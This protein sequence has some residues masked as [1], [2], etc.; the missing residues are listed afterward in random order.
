ML[1]SLSGAQTQGCF[2]LCCH[3]PQ[4]RIQHPHRLHSLSSEASAKIFRCE[5]APVPQVL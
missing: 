1:D 4:E 3:L 5:R 2:R